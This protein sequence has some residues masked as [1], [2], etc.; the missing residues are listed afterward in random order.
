[1]CLLITR[2]YAIHASL[3]RFIPILQRCN[4]L[5]WTF[6]G[7]TCNVPLAHRLSVIQDPI[8]TTGVLKFEF[9][10]V[11]LLWFEN[12]F[13]VLVTFLILKSFCVP[14]IQSVELVYHVCFYLGFQRC[15]NEFGHINVWHLIKWMSLHRDEFASFRIW[16]ILFVLFWYTWG[17][18]HIASIGSF[19]AWPS[20]RHLKETSCT[21]LSSH[22]V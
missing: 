10:V 18:I 5:L 9:V 7:W 6:V 13:E 17:D 21:G 1:M 3:R 12:E 22:N 15:G 11:I 14:F 2:L 4:H 20:T 19:Y 8:K 16:N